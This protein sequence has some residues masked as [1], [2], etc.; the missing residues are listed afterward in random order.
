MREVIKG[1]ECVKKIA[2]TLVKPLPEVI[3]H[4]KVAVSYGMI[5]MVDIFDVK[6]VYVLTERI[7][8]L[9]KS[10]RDLVRMKEYCQKQVTA[11]PTP[12]ELLQVVLLFNRSRTVEDIFRS[13]LRL[14]EKVISI[15]KLVR[16]CVIHGVLRRC[17]QVLMATG[18]YHPRRFFDRESY[19]KYFKTIR[20]THK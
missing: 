14:F 1:E 5:T 3:D 17:H 9:A 15:V 19:I 10:E 4:L 11:R 2:L 13:Q 8:E 16:F 6:N 18:G 20:E 7:H 12:H